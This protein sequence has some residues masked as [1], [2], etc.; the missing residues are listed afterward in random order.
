MEELL[1]GRVAIVTGGTSGIGRATAVEF[2]RHGAKVVIAGRRE[3]EGAETVRMIDEIGGQSSFIQADVSISEDVENLIRKTLELYER[4]DCAFNNAGY[5]GMPMGL[6]KT[7]EDEFDKI[8]STNLRGTFL[9]MKHEIA[10]MM[11]QGDGAIVNAGSINGLAANP[12]TSAYSAT[13]GGIIA[14]SR[15]AALEYARFGIRINV[16]SPGA[17][18]TD[19]LAPLPEEG[20]KK[21][22]RAHPLGRLGT[23]QEIAKVV[24]WLCS[25][26]A[27]YILGQNI[28]VDGGYTAQ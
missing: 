24:V 21:L 25:D 13:K 20:L 15:T 23:A 18:A 11:Q 4:I 27:S 19:M 7:A 17:I 26:R 3:S 10:A 2:A 6:T 9:C 8:I 22:A 1:D 28:M 16:V 12:G 5:A 14:L